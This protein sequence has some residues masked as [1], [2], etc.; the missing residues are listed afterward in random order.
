MSNP[1]TQ[2]Q[3]GLA[4]FVQVLKHQG[5]E[6]FEQQRPW[7]ERT[8]TYFLLG[9]AGRRTNIV[10]T[11]SF[12]SDLPSTVSYHPSLDQYARAVAG[13]VQFGSPELFFC[14]S[15]HAVLIELMWPIEIGQPM[16]FNRAWL[17]V[18][19]TEV[20]T[21]QIARCAIEVELGVFAPAPFDTVQ[22]VANRIRRS[23][24]QGRITFVERGVRQEQYQNLPFDGPNAL[25]EVGASSAGSRTQDFLAGKA[26]ILGFQLDGMLKQVWAADPWD[27]DYL[28]ASVK[29]LL[30]AAAVL[31]ARGLVAQGSTP[32]AIIAADKLVSDGWPTADGSPFVSIDQRNARVSELPS[33]E[34][35]NE[36]L[37]TV[38]DSK[39]DVALV[40]VDLDHFKQVN[41]TLGHIAGDGCLQRAVDAIVKVVR[42]KGTL[43]RWGGDEFAVLLRDFS[44]EEALATAER[45]RIEIESSESGGALAVTA[46][47]GVVATDRFAGSTSESLLH[48]ADEA[49]YRS[50]KSGRNRVTAWPLES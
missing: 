34:K 49:M 4:Q 12:L 21:D 11:D 20:R 42:R 24:D 19:V 14:E 13:R 37:R 31:R 6:V 48:S 26:F 28:R 46:S 16:R 10:L 8:V 15:G 2:L 22:F 43:Y 9:K 47:I 33:K 1:A 44:T 38:L 17:P 50:K 5:L 25:G 3:R 45:V 29:D 23:V 40:L 35:F 27:A 39:G 18:N 32:E 30:I 36:D 7:P 41:D